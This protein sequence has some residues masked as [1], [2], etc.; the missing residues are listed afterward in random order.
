MG[1]SNCSC[2]NNNADLLESHYEIKL[3]SSSIIA[4]VARGSVFNI[5]KN[6]LMEFK[7]SKLAAL[8]KGIP[9][10]TDGILR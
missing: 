6:R 10:S 4:L 1:I 9:E 5:E 8:M 7:D 3:N 2:L